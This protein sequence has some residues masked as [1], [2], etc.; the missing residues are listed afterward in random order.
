MIGMLLV[1]VGAI[2]AQAGLI[3]ERK[4]V[5]VPFSDSEVE[6][7]QDAAG[8]THVEVAGCMQ[9]DEKPGVP[10]LPVKFVKVLL[11]A[12]ASDVSLRH[13]VEESVLAQDVTVVPV[14]P[15]APLNQD[16]PA[17]VGPN[18]A[19][20][21][22]DSLF[23]AKSASLQ[24][25]ETMRGWRFVTVRVNPVRYVPATG[26]LFLATEVSLVLSYT[27]SSTRSTTAGAAATT[28]GDAL[29]AGLVGEMVVNP[30]DLAAYPSASLLRG[31]SL[32]TVDYLVIT[33]NTLSN[34]FQ[35]LADHRAA[36]KGVSTRVLTLDHIIS[37][38]SG[39][40]PSGGSDTQTA[41]RNCIKDYVNNHG[42]AYV[43]L[44]GDDTIVPDRDT[45]HT[46][47]S[48]TNIPTDL[49]Y[50]GLD[51]TWDADADGVYG[52]IASSSTVE[53]IDFAYDVIVAR[54]PVR[55]AAQAD[56][57]INKLIA[58]ETRPNPALNGKMLMCGDKLW[59]EWSDDARPTDLMNDGHAQFREHDPV[60]DAEAWTRRVY[61][62]AVQPYGD[63]APINFF[64]DTLTSWDTSTAG[65]YPQDGARLVQRYDEGWQH[66]FFA[67]H[68]GSTGWGTEVYPSYGTTQAGQQT[69]LT[70]FVY[71][72]ACNTGWFDSQWADPCLS[73]AFIRN[74]VGGALVYMGSSRYGWGGG[75][76]H[77]NSIGS[78][79]MEYSRSFYIRANETQDRNIGTAF[80]MHKMDKAANCYYHGPYRWVQCAMNLQGDPLIDLEGV[81]DSDGDGMPDAWEIA[82]GL[83]PNDP[84]D[85]ALD[86]DGDG[87]SNLQEFLDGTDPNV[88]NP[89]ESAYQ[90]MTLAGSFQGWNPT[91]ANMTLIADYTWQADLDF[92]QVSG[93]E[94]KFTADKSWT[95]NWGEANQNDLDIPLAGTV[96]QNNGNIRINGILDGTYRFTFNEQTGA[97]TVELRPELDSDGDGMVDSWEL[98]Y[99]FDIN[100]PN[101][102]Q[103]DPD[104]DGIVNVLE[105]QDGTNPRWA[106]TDL[107]GINDALDPD[108]LTPAFDQVT[109]ACTP[110]RS[111]RVRAES[112]T[113]S[114][115]AGDVTWQNE[116]F[117]DDAGALGFDLSALPAGAAI[118][119]AALVYTAS[120]NEP[121]TTES[122]TKIVDLGAL[123]PATDPC[124]V[125]NAI[126][127]AAGGQVPPFGSFPVASPREE[128]LG[129]N[130]A[131]INALAQA[132]PQWQ[133]GLGYSTNSAR[134]Y[135][136]SGVRLVV[137]Y[138]AFDS[139]YDFM[140]V[141]GTFQGWDPTAANMQLVDDYTWQADLTLNN[142]SAVRFKFVANKS[143]ALNWGESDQWDF[144]LDIAGYAESG[145][146]DINLNGALNGTYRF[147][148]NELTRAYTLREVPP[149]DTDG[150]GMPDAWETANGLNPNDASDAAQDPDGDGFSN[151]T[152]YRNGTDPNVY[153]P[154]DWETNYDFMTVAG[155]FQG[156]NPAAANMQLVGDYT[157]Q[158][159]IVLNNASGVEFKFTANKSWAVNWG[160]WNQGDYD[161]PISGYAEQNNGNIRLNGTLSGTFRFTYNEQTRS[162]SVAWLA[163]SGDTLPTAWQTYHGVT[164][165]ASDS[166][167][168]GLSNAE[169]Y[170][171]GG[172]PLATDTDGDGATDYEEAVAGTG[173]TD[174]SSSFSLDIA[175]DA[176]GRMRLS[177]PG[178]EGRRYR[179]EGA[180]DLE[181]P[182][183]E[184]LSTDTNGQNG[185][186]THETT[187]EQTAYRFFRARVSH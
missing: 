92:S 141:A 163:T 90:F 115:Q 73:E 179:I 135:H 124:A 65:D 58:Y 120:E 59:R 84:S 40:R 169:E 28:Q 54:I 162:Y 170:T 103:Q 80:A 68:G 118:Q 14:Q 114:W 63:A 117:Y 130:A 81:Q 70:V 88:F 94:F 49:Y 18:A 43:V 156:W 47:E 110:A 154:P 6:L 91:A 22:S 187:V 155:S 20:Y 128:M 172:N 36:F 159:D 74:P 104:G 151:L 139:N 32:G 145:A 137:S 19:I 140:T 67:T 173:I 85:A 101:D 95:M 82:N 3:S 185:T 76:A 106:D 10:R 75:S 111:G 60:S 55:T 180:T 136:L 174:R 56:A 160:E 147:K 66:I 102:A 121:Y 122:T 79:S 96:E 131:L 161:L 87:R 77:S 129:L 46:Y 134:D 150:D 119:H 152:E 31:G 89:W 13:S 148:F 30:S 144:D 45:Y 168:D 48:T 153:N 83:N 126:E 33:D 97:Y 29:F 34:R 4:V 64:F 125:Y 39:A 93:A 51:G 5:D 183:H 72:I 21:G 38:Y 164:A 17:F 167:G 132:S 25:V 41:I 149:T 61:Q 107:D 37:S 158:A 177:W 108:P 99:G 182:W 69:N 44:G 181:G 26:E 138:E 184:I 2:V 35:A 113:C 116:Q 146:A 171:L 178:A 9:A 23:P 78:T 12:D 100:N 133:L 109:I 127:S 53:E 123:N 98:L 7:S 50:S 142:Q 57:Y 11:P 157:W 176:Q 1:L 27:T 105:C 52:E 8:Y 175:G 16:R 15:D 112:G 86:P 24:Q 62:R 166:D 165:D 143:W 42:T 71:T 186:M